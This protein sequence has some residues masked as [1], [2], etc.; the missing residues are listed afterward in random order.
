MRH[1]FE[2][3]ALHTVV[4]SIISSLIKGLTFVDTKVSFIEIMDFVRGLLQNK[5]KKIS[6][7]LVTKREFLYF[8]LI[9][10]KFATCI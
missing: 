3:Y 8:L 10:Y 4:A 7:Q 5:L 2:K 1:S 6:W 9:K